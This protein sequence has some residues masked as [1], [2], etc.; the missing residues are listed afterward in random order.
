MEIK[1]LYY[2]FYHCNGMHEALLFVGLKQGINIGEQKQ[3]LTR[4]I[5]R[6]HFTIISI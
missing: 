3:Q 5:P 6:W 1:A 2:Y 4:E